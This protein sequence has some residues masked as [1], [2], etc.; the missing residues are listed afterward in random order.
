MGKKGVQGRMPILKP[1]PDFRQY[2][3]IGSPANGFPLIELLVVLAI[4]SL[5][6]VLFI[7]VGSRGEGIQKKSDIAKL[8][9][10]IVQARSDARETSNRTLFNLGNYDVELKP[11]LGDSKDLTFYPDGSAN[12]GI[13]FLENQKLFEVRWID[14]AIVK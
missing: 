9:S 13:L 12:G 7:G 2:P 1:Y 3:G 10:A 14:G 5:A 8:E 4:M 11:S 6:A